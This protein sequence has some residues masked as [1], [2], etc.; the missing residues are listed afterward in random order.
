MGTDSAFGT[1]LSTFDSPSTR[2]FLFSVNKDK[3]IRRG[4]FVQ[5]ALGDGRLIGRVSDVFKTNRYYMRPESVTSY[6][7]S[8]AKINEI[9]PA[10]DWE[11]MVADVTTMGIFDGSGFSESTFP[12]SPGD[13]VT[14][15]EAGILEKFFGID[16]KGLNIGKV[17][18]HGID[19][20][21][22][23][24]KLLQKHLAILA[25]SGAG[26]SFLTGVII[27]EIMAR[28]KKESISVVV[29]DTHGEYNT[30]FADDKNYAN[31]TKVFP[32]S[33]LRI[34]LANISPHQLGGFVNLTGP[35]IRELAKVW[36]KSKEHS[37]TDLVEA[38]EKSESINVKTKET[39]I[40]ALDEIGRTGLFGPADYPPLDD[41]AR[42][43]Q[44]S[45]IDLSEEINMK[46]K[47]IIVSYIASK[48]FHSRRDGIIPPFLLV[49]EEAHQYA[50][51][52]AK[53]EDALSRGILQT[54][55][56]EGRKFQSCL[57]LISQRPVNLSTTILSQCNTKVILR[58]TNPYDLE[59]IGESSEAITKDVLNQIT[60]LPV[61]TALVVGEAVNFPLFVRVRKRRSK[62][63]EKGR[64]LEEA[65]AEFYEK[66]EQMRKDAKEFM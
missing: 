29:I 57:C 8:G 19:A 9:F 33:D 22:N 37:I 16:Q 58:V 36:K 46:K 13:Q 43:G 15:P 30:C 10:G 45:V 32:S 62:E 60:T 17:S 14:E 59:H 7:N 27:E 3:V 34:G 66:T 5:V 52:K 25:M 31:R 40:S 42:Q 20:C 12:P 65:A 18:Y 2:R 47:Q 1:I 28:A 50:P 48:L 21:L 49:L 23:L 61:G 39:I 54:I 26:K 35:Q 53:K 64:S 24:T 38:V 11:C 4:Q 41:I 44:V 55:A 51:E 63:S 6:E 56:R